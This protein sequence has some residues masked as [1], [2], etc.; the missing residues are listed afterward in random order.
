MESLTDAQVMD[1]LR[2]VVRAQRELEVRL[3]ALVD[4]VARR[5]LAQVHGAKNPVQLLRQVLNWTAGEAAAVLRLAAAVTP[6]RMLTGAVL[7]PLH[8]DTAAAFAAGEVSARSADIVTRTGAGCRLPA[9]G[10]VLEQA[11]SSVERVLLDVARS[12]DTDATARHATQIFMALD[13]DG[14]LRD[15]E[16]AQRR[17]HVDLHRLPDGSGTLTAYLTPE[18]AEYVETV[19]DTLGQPDPAH[20]GVRDLR[21]PGQRRHDA[22][23]TALRLLFASGTLPSA[24]GV[25]TMLVLTMDA[26]HFATD[27]GVAATGH[28]YPVP[29]PVAKRWL[30]PEAR[31]LLTL[32]T[33]TKAIVAYSTKQRLFSATQRWAMFARDRGCTYP[34]CDAGLAWL[35]GHHV[36]DWRD[37]HRTAV[38]DGT[39]VCGTH[40]DTFQ[41]MGWRSAMLNGR[42]HWIPPSWVDPERKPQRNHQH[43]RE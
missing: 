25:A 2:A 12:H 38:D 7:A 33:K 28:G 27:T 26:D 39:L 15:H 29:V 19:F 37:T 35:D 40:H 23:L 30:D 42:P 13:Q 16:R 41:Q 43:D 31:V 20:D 18:A 22:L 8:E 21:T 36:T 24:G 14:A 6:R 4:Q 9:A 17:R 10:C 3:V 11:H 1:G 32:L 5:D 34:G